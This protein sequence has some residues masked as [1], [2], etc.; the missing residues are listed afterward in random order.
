[1]KLKYCSSQ[2]SKF[3]GLMFSFKNQNKILV[4]DF[5]Q[6]KN[7]SLHM[8]FVFYQ[9]DVIFL[10]SKK[11]VVELKSSFKPFS[12]YTS[13]NKAQYVLECPNGYIKNKGVK[14][15]RIIRI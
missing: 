14:I 4:F 13:K 15:G 8:F 9:I 7:I 3:I 2:L 5:K 11:K 6:E 1:M 12:L 10:N